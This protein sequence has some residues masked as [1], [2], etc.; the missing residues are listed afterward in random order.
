VILTFVLLRRLL[1]KCCYPFTFKHALAWSS[2]RNPCNLLQCERCPRVSY[3][4][5]TKTPAQYPQRGR[6]GAWEPFFC[7]QDRELDVPA[8]AG[9]R[10][11]H[12]RGTAEGWNGRGQ[13]HRHYHA[14]A[15]YCSGLV[16]RSDLHWSSSGVCRRII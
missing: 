8:A 9:S 14:Y 16:S 15:C 10:S 1:H 4:P 3:H 2:S 11:P 6:R 13:P 12:C 7:I 5:C